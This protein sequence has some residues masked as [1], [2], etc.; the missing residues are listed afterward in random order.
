MTLLSTVSRLAAV[1]IFATGLSAFAAETGSAKETAKENA[2]KT[3]PTAADL[4]KLLDE[5]GKQRD[6]MIS[7][8]DAL[9][10]QL[11]DATEEQRKV[12]REKMESQ[13]KAF[14]EVMNTLHKQIRDEQRKQRQV[15]TKR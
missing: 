7:D 10:K 15:P 6:Q 8:Y 2:K 3:P 12:I 4:R 11:K 1:A 14:E 9:A 13:K 5:A